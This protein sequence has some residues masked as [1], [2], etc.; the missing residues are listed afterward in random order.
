MQTRKSIPM[1]DGAPGKLARKTKTA[2]F[3]GKNPLEAHPCKKSEVP[4]DA[5]PSN[6]ATSKKIA[7]RPGAAQNLD[8]QQFKL[9]QDRG[10]GRESRG[11]S[12]RLLK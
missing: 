10:N 5:R 2:Q 8:E 4:A 1:T 11:K 6:C 7:R 12:A 3:Q 9:A